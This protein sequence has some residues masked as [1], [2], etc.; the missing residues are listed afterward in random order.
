MVAF[1]WTV[2][3]LMSAALVAEIFALV[4]LALVA[5]RSTRRA[6]EIGD[7]LKQSVEPS[8][9]LAKEVQQSLQ[10]HLETISLERN[11][12]ASLV[13]SRSKTLQ[14]VLDDTRRRSDRIRLRFVEGVQ[15]VE[16]RPARRGI[17]REVIEP[18]QTAGQVSRG[19]KIALWILRR[20]A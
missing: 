6:V 13:A 5:A 7:Q 1:L 3:I 9:R 2:I 10:S 17:Y 11:E 18:I 16:G 14:A 20:V 12:I 15:T 19:L 8:L 4:G